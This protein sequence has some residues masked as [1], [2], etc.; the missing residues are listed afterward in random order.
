MFFSAGMCPYG[1]EAEQDT[2]LYEI[3]LYTRAAIAAIPSRNNGIKQ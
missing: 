2:K 3:T 1:P